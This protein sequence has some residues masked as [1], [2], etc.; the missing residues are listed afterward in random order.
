MLFLTRTFFLFSGR[1]FVQDKKNILRKV[2]HFNPARACRI[3]IITGSL[4]GGMP[5]TDVPCMKEG[6]CFIPGPTEDP[7]QD[8]RMMRIPVLHACFTLEP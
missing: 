7:I 5:N 1:T 8:T 6:L 4:D 3:Y 2:F